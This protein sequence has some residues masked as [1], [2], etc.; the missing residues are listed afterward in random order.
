LMTISHEDHIQL[1]IQAIN[2]SPMLSDG[3]Q[4]LKIH[5]AAHDFGIP[6]LT[7]CDWIQGIP[8]CKQAHEHECLLTSTQEDVLVL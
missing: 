5:T 3:T 2:N 1:A 7:L 6:C 8:T 4:K